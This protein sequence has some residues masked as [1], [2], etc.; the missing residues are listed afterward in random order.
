MAAAVAAGTG[1]GPPT[2]RGGGPGS[3]RAHP[4]PAPAAHGGQ[5]GSALDVRQR[6]AQIKAQGASR[7]WEAAVSTLQGARGRAEADSRLFTAAL[8]ACAAAQQWART[9]D[10][11]QALA[12]DRLSL[13][14][15]CYTPAVIACARRGRW[16]ESVGLLRAGL[17][18]SGGATR[19]V[20]NLHTYSAA[21]G[22]CSS[23]SHWPRAAA[24]LEDL[25]CRG[26]VP[27]QF[28]CGAAMSSL[29]KG[30]QWSVGLA[31]LDTEVA[32]TGTLHVVTCNSLVSACEKG[33]H[34]DAALRVFADMQLRRLRCDVITFTSVISACA[35]TEQRW[36][37]AVAL[38][39]DMPRFWATP[40]I[41][42]YN[43]AIN[44]CQRAGRSER[45]LALLAEARRRGLR[46]D[47]VACDTALRACEAAGKW[48]L[49]LE[50]WGEL[51]RAAPRRGLTACSSALAACEARGPRPQSVHLAR[52][53]RDRCWALLPAGAAAAER[54]GGLDFEAFEAVDALRE[55]EAADGALARA[56]ARR[57]Y[58][59]V[60][61]RLR[62]LAAAGWRPAA[63]QGD[64]RLQE[65]VL[66]RQPGI[67]QSLTAR[68]LRVVG[69]A[70]V[71]GAAAPSWAGLARRAARRDLPRAL[72]EAVA[73]A[74]SGLESG[75]ECSPAVAAWAQCEVAVAS[76][77]CGPPA[78]RSRGRVVRF[79]QDAW[80]GGAALAPVFREHDRSQHAE[81]RA[82]LA[83]VGLV[84][85]RLRGR[86]P[87]AAGG[88]E[89]QALAPA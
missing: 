28:C 8:G 25:A 49:A 50:L 89:S 72:G 65:P 74:P 79:G 60:L 7:R 2:P 11:L 82:L 56:L 30:G 13:D 42:T 84:R 24:L 26:L 81:R 45:A 62:W 20:S 32:S 37:V 87:H 33:G 23:G 86:R 31:L 53:L 4:P 76:A 29:E 64:A 47:E 34:W 12:S 10:L 80:P 38:L 88:A 78:H 70:P 73:A 5:L 39:E 1:A 83:V 3:R 9:L 57:L 21:I 43:A 19:A 63:R 35:G 48:L 14:A 75:P 46:P 67:G 41:V 52:Q 69:C 68:A 15:M 16:A 22:S 71:G 51:A 6:M 40:N 36:E 85:L 54:H 17:E 61:E 27:D 44:A 18:G 55:R 58:A 77:P 66:E 59:P